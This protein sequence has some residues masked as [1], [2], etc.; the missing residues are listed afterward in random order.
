MPTLTTF[1]S[2]EHFRLSLGMLVED[3]G[4]ERELWPGA[5]SE[6]TMQGLVHAKIKD[7]MAMVEHAFNPSTQK[8]SLYGRSL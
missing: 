1:C 5:G 8:S 6:L 2:W 4:G 3:R 7:L